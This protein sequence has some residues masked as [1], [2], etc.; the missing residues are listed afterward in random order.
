MGSTAQLARAQPNKALQPPS[1]SVVN[2][3]PVEYGIETCL[4]LLS[5]L[6]ARLVVGLDTGR[7]RPVAA[8][9]VRARPQLSLDPL[10]G[11]GLR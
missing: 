3:P 10:G 7:R 1:H 5:R 8:G 6:K 9:I 2:Q 11:A 4:L